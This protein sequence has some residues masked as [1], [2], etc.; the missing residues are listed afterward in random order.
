MRTHNNR[1]AHK[2]NNN[3]NNN[4]NSR[5]RR[6]GGNNHH[7]G[8]N[9]PRTDIDDESLMI[10]PQQRRHAVNQ[11]TKYTDLAKNARQSGERIEYEYYMQHVEHYVRTINLADEQQR[12]KDDARRRDHESRSQQRPAHSAEDDVTTPEEASNAAP[13][14]VAQQQPRIEHPRYDQR[15]RI[16]RPQR[17]HTAQ[18][19]ND[20]AA[21]PEQE[22]QTPEALPTFLLKPQPLADDKAAPQLNDDGTPRIPRRRGRPKRR[23]DGVIVTKEEV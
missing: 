22:A 6:G 23:P 1:H 21:T 9:R 19:P 8:G 2:H 14:Q 17:H 20:K 12:T 13:P 4:N 11:Q 10:S 5:F 3:N 18:Q 16:T 7:N 15:P